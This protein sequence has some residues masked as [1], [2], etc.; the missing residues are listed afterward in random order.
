MSIKKGELKSSP[1]PIVKP[2]TV[3]DYPFAPEGGKG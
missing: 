2:C 3:K 1:F